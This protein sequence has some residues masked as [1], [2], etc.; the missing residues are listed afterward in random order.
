MRKSLGT[1]LLTALWC[2]PC[3]PRAEVRSMTMREAVAL[4]LKQSPEVVIARYEQ[5]KGRAAVQIARDPF[6]PKV[7]G[8]SGAAFTSG[9]PV[10]IN[11]QPPSIF[12]AQTLM[13][14]Y[15]RPQS[16]KVAEAR[17]NT[18][19]ADIEATRQQDEVAY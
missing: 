15:N 6:V 19:G 13:S 12:A 16:Y 18:R 8:G 7:V 17:E 5:A 4:A 3:A 10:S 11:G 14:L 2:T 1:L 9:C